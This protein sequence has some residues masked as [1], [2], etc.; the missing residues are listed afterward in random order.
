MSNE[1]TGLSGSGFITS[2][3]ISGPY[4]TDKTDHTTDSNQLRY[5]KYLRSTI[6]NTYEYGESKKIR[7]G[8]DSELGMPWEYYNSMGNWFVDV[9]DF[10]SLLKK[11]D[12]LAAVDLKVEGKK[13]VEVSA[14]LWTYA[15]VDLWLNGEH[16]CK[17]QNPVY[18]PILSIPVK[19]KLRTGK[20][21]LYI[22]M[23]N[24]GVR[25]TRNIFGIQ[26]LDNLDKVTVALPDEKGV[27]PFEQISLWLSSIQLK[28][29]EMNFET[30]AP[31]GTTLI[32]DSRNPDLTKAEQR[33]REID[34]SGKTSLKLPE[35]EPYIIIQGKVGDKNLSRRFEVAEDIKPLHTPTGISIKENLELAFRRIADVV[36]MDRGE[37]VG[38]SMNNILARTYFGEKLGEL[39]DFMFNQTLDQINSRID[40]SDFLMCGLL[41]YV[42]NYPVNEKHAGKTKDVI[43]NY[44]YWMNQKGSDGMCFWS[45]NHALM[46]YSSAMI[47]GAMYP[48]EYFP[49]AEMTGEALSRLGL[50]RVKEWLDDIGSEGFEEFLSAGYMCVT[51]GALLNVIDFGEESLAKQA[52][53][54]VD[55]L[56]Q[57]LC[58]HALKGVVFAPQGRVYRDVVYPFRQ[59]VQALVNMIEP[60]APFALDEWLIFMAT[61]SYKLP[62]GLTQLMNTP[63]NYEY[64]TGN[65][66]IRL[67]KTKDY[68]MTSVQSP[69]EDENPKMWDNI[70]FDES[71]DAAS[72][73]YVKS[74]N[75]R[76][77]GTTRFEPGVYGYQQHMWCAAIDVDNV[78]FANHPG[79]AVDASSMRPGYWY[80]NG[81]MPAVKQQQ[82][83]IGSIYVIPENHPIKFTHLHW[84]DVLFD[85]MAQMQGWIFGRKKDSYLGVWCS[86][87]MTRINDILFD[88]EF[89][90]DSEEA[91]YLCR[92]SSVHESGSFSAFIAECMDKRPS[93]DKQTLTL[94][95]T[96]EFLLRYEK[97]QDKTQYI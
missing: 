48:Q 96:D 93:F 72:Y 13:E 89:R 63:A 26:L 64:S 90:A 16:I 9:S 55:Q 61:S 53:A 97:H 80:G 36:Q 14:C 92:G 44:R 57:G 28:N 54:V 17:A 65:A 7:I 32:L 30:P 23:Q 37:D 43:L 74:L 73:L 41:R 58:R 94:T 11:I 21:L 60:S 12:L 76:F 81:V 52:A 19:L 46:F 56:L 38:F 27:K 47:A 39:D 3:M 10:Y 83:T 50:K 82:N 20:N 85:E 42:K 4:I 59:G 8:A 62:E 18:K 2:Y 78:V 95:T 31:E 34:I 15:A 49:R 67:Y 77:H 40:C 86:E 35:G 87:T 66:L 22:R 1:K 5:E 75:E 68:L 51:F 84:K 25:D 88:A 45:E 91:A 24:L 70:S 69:R 33:F 79:A 29:Q 71:S 6:A